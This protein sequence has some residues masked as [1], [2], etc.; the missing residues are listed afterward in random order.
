VLQTVS[1]GHVAT[2]VEV[3]ETGLK[4]VQQ[5]VIHEGFLAD[6]PMKKSDGGKWVLTTKSP[7]ALLRKT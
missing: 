2:V 4:I 6:I 7:S 5:N 1:Y 3:N